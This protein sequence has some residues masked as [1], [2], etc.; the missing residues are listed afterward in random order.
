MKKIAELISKEAR[1]LRLSMLHRSQEALEEYLKK[2]P[3]ANPANHQVRQP[4][5][6]PRSKKDAPNKKEM[7]EKAEKALKEVG[8]TPKSNTFSKY[9]NILSSGS[10][11]T[12]FDGYGSLG[13]K[14]IK[15]KVG[16][17]AYILSNAK[18]EDPKN[19]SQVLGL[20]GGEK[21]HADALM[22]LI[23]SGSFEVPTENLLSE[24]SFE[25]FSKN[26]KSSLDTILKKTKDTANK[27][28]KN[29]PYGASHLPDEVSSLSRKLK[30]ELS[31]SLDSFKDSMSYNSEVESLQAVKSYLD[32]EK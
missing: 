18:T 27:K 14:E 25:E 20:S 13:S 21:E 19:I 12:D 11:K 16:S 10:M 17:L 26:M 5:E 2:H 28:Y 8:I 4:K 15:E 6:K 7:R 30:T 32:S 29:D 24:D 1:S 3:R 23:S 31:S 22:T 9:E